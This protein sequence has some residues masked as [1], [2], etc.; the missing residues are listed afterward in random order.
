MAWAT[1]HTHTSRLRY[2]RNNLLVPVFTCNTTK[3]TRRR[4]RRRHRRRWKEKPNVK[5]YPNFNTSQKNRIPTFHDEWIYGC[6]VWNPY[7]LTVLHTAKCYQSA[8]ACRYCA[9]TMDNDHSRPPIV[10]RTRKSFVVV[11]F[12]CCSFRFHTCWLICNTEPDKLFHF[13]KK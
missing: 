13:T 9:P 1:A 10:R 6:L 4:R 2:T 12:C 8:C 11:F 5:L 7:A 3:Y